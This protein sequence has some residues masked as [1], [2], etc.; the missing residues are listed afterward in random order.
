[1]A[2]ES[3]QIN[4][5][6]NVTDQGFKSGLDAINS[7]LNSAMQRFNAVSKASRDLRLSVDGTETALRGLSN[8]L[9]GISGSVA[10][11]KNNQ[12]A[13]AVA[14]RQTKNA[15]VELNG[16]LAK[17]K[18]QNGQVSASTQRVLQY[19]KALEQSYKAIA[20]SAKAADLKSV[21]TAYNTSAQ[22]MNYTAMRLTAGLTLPLTMFMRKGFDSLKRLNEEQIRTSKLLDDSGVSAEQLSRNLTNLDKRLDSLTFKWGISRELVQGLAGDFAE[23]GISSPKALAQLTQITTEV[24]KLGNVDITQSQAFV[25]SIYQNIT[26]I[27]REAGQNVTLSLI[28]I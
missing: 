17:E 26:R 2:E 12:L 7:A 8:N 1:M 6:A 16:A 10:T 21:A 3:G 22:R 18:A 27:K 25:Q 19:N 28:H 24:E 5:E 14:Y 23:L 20:R 9:K 13:L 4:V 15:V 11:L